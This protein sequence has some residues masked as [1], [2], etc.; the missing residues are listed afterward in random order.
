VVE[1][2]K[3]LIEELGV[4]DYRDGSSSY[5]G[6]PYQPIPFAEFQDVPSQKGFVVRQEAA[7]VFSHM[8]WPLELLPD[9]GPRAGYKPK[10]LQP[11]GRGV[12][13][14]VHSVL[15]VGANV[16]FYSLLAAKRGCRVTAVERDDRNARILRALATWQQLNVWVEP[17]LAQALSSEATFDVALLLNV[18]HWIHKQLGSARTDALICEIGRRARNVYFQTPLEWNRSFYVVPGLKSPEDVRLYLASVRLT[19]TLIAESDHHTNDPRYLFHA[20]GRL[21]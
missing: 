15:D 14:E 2:I 19:A 18:H 10:P 6:M 9:V 1:A 8:G 3:A 17:D 20:R 13:G 16:G 7:V 11:V 5:H 4:G 12:L 21:Q